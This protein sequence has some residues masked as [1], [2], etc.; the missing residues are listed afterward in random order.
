MQKL[1]LTLKQFNEALNEAGMD[2]EIYDLAG[3]LSDLSLYMAHESEAMRAEGHEA[4]A[5]IYWE[6]SHRI[7]NYLD[8]LG[9]Y[10][11]I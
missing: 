10:D 11:E 7:Y 9:Y 6:R 2:P 1:K 5:E 3:I 8:R 4:R